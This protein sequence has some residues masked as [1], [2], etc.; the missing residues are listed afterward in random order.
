VLGPALRRRTFAAAVAALALVVGAPAAS[1]SPSAK[2]TYLRAEGAERCPD[3]A[4]LKRAVAARLGYDVFFPWAKTTVVVEITRAPKGFHGAVKFVDARG[5]VKG[6]RALDSKSDDCADVVRALAL[7][8]SIAIDDF[9]LDDVPKPAPAPEPAPV[10]EP[11][12]EPEPAPEPAPS[13]APAPEPAPAPA[14]VSA[15]PPRRTELAL[16]VAPTVSFGVAPAAAVGAHVDVDVRRGPLSIG[17][18]ARADLPSSAAAPQGGR[19]STHLLLAS[20]VPCVRALAPLAL[21]A[22]GSFG[23][24]F[25]SGAGLAAPSSGSAPFAAVG[26]RVAAFIPVTDRLFVA[27][28]VDVLAA[29]TRHVVQIDD[30]EAFHV[31]PASATLGLGAGA[32]F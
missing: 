16:W 32:R 7:T 29:L 30:A 5:V 11:E 23:D 19:V 21:C 4:E 12:P 24:F 13:P 3:E 6:Q 31:P 10:P 25:E 1:A 2:L 28:H 27:T 17:L 20:V 9:G 15:T 26:G 14:P 18:E 22:V 8:V